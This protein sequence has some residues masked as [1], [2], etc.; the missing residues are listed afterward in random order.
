MTR[1]IF[2]ALALALTAGCADVTPVAPAAPPA[3]P[4]V[5]QALTPRA[6]ITVD[7]DLADVASQAVQLWTDATG[8][9][10]AP[11]LRIT[12]D[13]VPGA[14]QIRL[15]PVSDCGGRIDS[16][17]CWREHARVI[18]VAVAAPVDVRVSS[19]AHEIGHTLGLV[20]EDAGLM[21]NERSTEERLHPCVSAENV[22][23]AGFDGP[24]ACL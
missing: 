19:I 23:D 16:W 2:A 22:Q 10:F 4:E 5:T 17:G 13:A 12:T 1:G 9:A 24:G 11:E 15:V 3:A 8:G 7:A 21:W 14:L 20:H 18:E 6:V